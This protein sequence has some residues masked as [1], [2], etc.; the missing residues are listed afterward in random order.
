MS[1]GFQQLTLQPA[2]PNA[3]AIAFPIPL[4]AP[5]TITT[6]DSTF[7][8]ASVAAS[9]SVATCALTPE[10]ARSRISDTENNFTK[11]TKIEWRIEEEYR[12]S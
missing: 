9:A 1:N 11:K 3:N 5:V 10:N 8:T 2:L 12:L 4:E 6:G 7:W